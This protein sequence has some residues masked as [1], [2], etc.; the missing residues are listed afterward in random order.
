MGGWAAN[1]QHH[2]HHHLLHTWYKTGTEYPYTFR[3]LAGEKICAVSGPDRVLVTKRLV[4][5]QLPTVNILA[6]WFGFSLRSVTK[7]AWLV[8]VEDET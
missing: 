6:L 5:S 8:N 1:K 7:F 4:N 3:L 2:H